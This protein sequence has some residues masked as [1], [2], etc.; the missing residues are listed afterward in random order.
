MLFLFFFKPVA[1]INI[2]EIKW[3]LE[4]SILQAG[5][6][7]FLSTLIGIGLARAVLTIPRRTQS[8]VLSLLLVPQVL[9]VLFSILIVLS[10][11]SPFPM[12]SIGVITTFTFINSG[13]AG[14]ILFHAVKKNLGK[15]GFI[16][17]VYGI[18]QFK[19]LY[20]ILVPNLKEDIKQCFLTIFLFCFTSISVPLVVGG[21]R[22]T[23]LEV[24]IYE[25]IFIDQNWSVAWIL[26][27]LQ[28]LLVVSLSYLIVRTKD[29]YQQDYY[30]TSRLKSKFSLSI[31]VIYLL[32]YIGGYLRSVYFSLD[33]FEFLTSY[34]TELIAAFFN[35]LN[36]YF[37]TGFLFVILFLIWI[38]YFVKTLQHVWI[39][40]LFSV[41]TILV[42]FSLYL[43][44][45]AAAIYDYIKIPLGFSF[46]IFVILFRSF[47]MN[48]LENLK[49]QLIVTHVYGMSFKDILF[50]IIWP[51][52]KKELTI[53]FSILFIWQIS[54]FAILKSLG[55]QVQTLGL[56][57][58]GFM[59]SYRLRAAILISFLIL[60][61]WF[62][63]SATV[64]VILNINFRKNED[65][66]V[67]Y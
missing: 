24:L 62:I 37:L 34:K 20:K 44:F 29:Q 57:A 25:K 40:H 26:N 22:G 46:L 50:Y 19:F 59:S 17:D 10:L 58:E 14:F 9:P 64:F 1:S 60:S 2:S 23:N 5:V 52:T 56:M 36:L 6:A 51:Q 4:N 3:A 61:L 38:F 13:L 54:D 49:S 53:C 45:P 63:L 21:G 11:I 12:G 8:A 16:S 30:E 55:T 41:S 18:P 27:L 42:G 39:R 47:Y 28:T 66:R 31:L 48:S 15:L 43:L 67:E 7:A 35:S 33:E 65:H 32:V